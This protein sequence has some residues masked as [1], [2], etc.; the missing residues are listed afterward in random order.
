MTPQRKPLRARARASQWGVQ[1]G[2]QEPIVRLYPGVGKVTIAVDYSEIPKLIDDLAR[3][4]REH[5][6]KEDT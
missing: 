6:R 3:L 2:T 1:D 5:Q 4:L